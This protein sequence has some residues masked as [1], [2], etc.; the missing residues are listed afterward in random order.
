MN[1]EN[2]TDF[3]IIPGREFGLPSN[4]ICVEKMM[5]ATQEVFLYLFYGDKK[6]YLKSEIADFL[7]QKNLPS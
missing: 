6:Y 2:T 3:T 5:P 4:E 7:K 1:A